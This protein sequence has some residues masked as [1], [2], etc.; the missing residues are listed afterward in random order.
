MKNIYEIAIEELIKLKEDSKYSIYNQ[1]TKEI[2]LNLTSKKGAVKNNTFNNLPLHNKLELQRLN[3]EDEAIDEF[4]S[5]LHLLNDLDRKFK[6]LIVEYINSFKD[7]STYEIIKKEL[8]TTIDSNYEVVDQQE[9]QSKYILINAIEDLF[10]VQYQK[11]SLSNLYFY[12]YT[13]VFGYIS[14][15]YDDLLEFLADFYVREKCLGIRADQRAKDFIFEQRT[16]NTN[17]QVENIE[18]YLD[19]GGKFTFLSYSFNDKLASFL[20]FLEAR[21][22]GVLLF[23]DWMFSKDFL[24]A[25]GNIDI[26]KRSIELKDSLDYFLK[27]SKNLMFL[28]SINSELYTSVTIRGNFAK[29][30]KMVR[31]WCAWEIG[32]FYSKTMGK[33]R[34]RKFQYSFHDTFQDEHITQRIIKEDNNLLYNLDRVN[35]FSSI[36]SIL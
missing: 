24:N 13:K 10:T 21:N 36:V 2:Y 27:A 19:I 4:I 20:V 31:Q 33:N 34:G 28:R 6:E 25:E 23:I 12:F 7:G 22:N 17:N 5:I 11:S 1:K 16:Q 14:E 3:P 9:N 30:N 29:N 15:Y 18:S 26:R 35:N 8:L 32:S